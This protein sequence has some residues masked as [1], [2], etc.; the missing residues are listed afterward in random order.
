MPLAFQSSS[1]GT[2]PF[3]YFNIDT[4][5][6]LMNRLLWFT[7][8]FTAAVVSLAGAPP[9][10]LPRARFD[11]FE[12]EAADLGHV[13]G[14]IHGYDR[15]GLIGDS[16]RHFP[17]PE[18]PEDFRQRPEGEDNRPRMLELLAARARPREIEIVALADGVV[19]VCGFRFERAWF[20][21]LVAYVWRGGYP[22]WRDGRRPA[23]VVGMRRSLEDSTHPLFSDQR[24]ELHLCPC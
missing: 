1:H 14:A 7:P 23:C 19:D 10:E 17:F 15:S 4:D 9:G 5:L 16:Y 13:M 12:V 11:G 3:G 6:L 8:E 21:E 24:W 20:G 2:L 18:R 22:R